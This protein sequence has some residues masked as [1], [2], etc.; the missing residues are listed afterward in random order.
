MSS[1]AGITVPEGE[2]GGLRSAASQ[3]GTVAGTLSGISGELRGMPGTMA[4][5]QGPA[6]V[7]YAGS[8]M[9]GGSSAD[10][11]VQALGTAERAARA[12]GD[13]LEE[14]QDEAERAIELAREAQ[15]RIDQAERDIADAQARQAAAWQAA[16]SAATEIALGTLTA[17]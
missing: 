4:S 5:W 8:C 17:T 2:P 14:A 12:Y 1:F 13:A 10:A 11:A 15:Q 7:S 6:S 9:T 16:D 3:L